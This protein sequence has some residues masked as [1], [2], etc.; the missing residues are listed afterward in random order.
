[1]PS[2]Y[3]NVG[4]LANIGESGVHLEISRQGELAMVKLNTSQDMKS[5]NLPW[6]YGVDVPT[7]NLVLRPML[8][9]TSKYWRNW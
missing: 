9:V 4:N 7:L 2:R 3:F 5:R 1:M 8:T 6:L